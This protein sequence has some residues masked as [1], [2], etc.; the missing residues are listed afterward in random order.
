MKTH[1]EICVEYILDTEAEDF[2]ENPSR[3]HVY[4]SAMCATYGEAHA[5][6]EL[7][8]AVTFNETGEGK[9]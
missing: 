9:T 6:R 2:D 8:D 1:T 3:N 5:E 7:Q 4:F